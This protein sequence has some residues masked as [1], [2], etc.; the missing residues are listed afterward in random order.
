MK[1]GRLDARGWGHIH[2]WRQ[3]SPTGVPDLGT[4]PS[5][6]PGRDPRTAR[7]A[8]ERPGSGPEENR[9]VVARREARYALKGQAIAYA[10][11]I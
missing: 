8:V 6:V 11:N 7:T 5:G 1:G 4:T 3:R 2:P 10:T 9:S